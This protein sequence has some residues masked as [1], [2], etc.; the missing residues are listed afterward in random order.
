M[1]NSG[2]RNDGVMR[3]RTISKM[4]LP[5]AAAL[6]CAAP[7]AATLTVKATVNG[8]ASTEALTW[9]VVRPGGNIVQTGVLSSRMNATATN[10]DGMLGGATMA[11]FLAFCIEPM[12]FVP[13]G[14]A[15]DYHLV[16]LSRAASGLGGI[17]ATK[18]D[19]IR[20]LFGRFAP[21][22]GAGTMTALNSIAFQ[23]AIWEIVMETPGNALNVESTAANK[24]NFYAARTRNT[25]GA[26]LSA[27]NWL[28]QLDG[29]GPMAT[30]LGVL[31]NG[32]FGV[33]GSGS[34]DLLVFGVPEPASWAMLIAGFGLVGASLRR[35]RVAAVGA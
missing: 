5:V 33:Q 19:L 6:A 30:R 2:L 15:A 29:T 18:A 3:V 17:G 1:A 20:E 14:T 9:T 27:N 12:E 10:R 34:Q 8:F 4:A 31:Q 16:T 22:G 25:Q 23:L 24:G 11:A 13:V 26:F 32:T 35:R 21:S 7:A 28:R